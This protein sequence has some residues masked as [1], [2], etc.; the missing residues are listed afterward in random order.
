RTSIFLE[1]ELPAL[2]EDVPLRKREELIFQYDGAPAHFS[3]QVRNVLDTCYPNRWMD[4][5][6]L[7]IWPARSPDLN[8]FDYFV[9]GHIKNLVEHLR[10]DTE[11]EMRE[12]ILAAFNIITPET[13]LRAKL[14]EEPK[15]VYE[16]E[17]GTSNNSCIKMQERIRPTGNTTLKKM[18]NAIY[19]KV[20]WKARDSASSVPCHKKRKVSLIQR[21]VPLQYG[22]RKNFFD[23]N[24]ISLI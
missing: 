5:G 17:D 10:D 24:I 21:N 18:R 11:A 16:N 19:R 2:F 23:F 3:R 6:D 9:W 13:A 22:S 1:N 20:V 12:A 15:S 14:L 4:R 7:I 8:V